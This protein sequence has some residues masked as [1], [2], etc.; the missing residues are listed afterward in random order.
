M[1]GAKIAGRRV[2]RINTCCGHSLYFH[3][4][5]LPCRYPPLSLNNRTN[6]TRSSNP[7]FPSMITSNRR[8]G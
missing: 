1:S 5:G 8:S 4:I 2:R 7:S 6:Q 3:H